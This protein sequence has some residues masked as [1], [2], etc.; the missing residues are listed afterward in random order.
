MR[1]GKSIRILIDTGSNRNYIQPKF[2]NNPI[3][4]KAP[5]N[6]VSVG[7]STI[8]THH[9]EANLFNIPD[10]KVKFF[11][12]PT[13]KSF[14]AILG[15]DS[16][17][18]LGAEIKI[19][20][21]IMILKNG[22]KIPIKE[23]TF[24]AVNT[25]IPRT[26]HLSD[27]QKAK[28]SELLKSFPDL[29]ADPNQKLT[30]TTN[31]KAT[32]RTSSDT[33]VYSKFYQYPMTLK[34][35]VNKQI[36]ELLEDGIIRPS[37]SPYNSPVW[38]VPKKADASGEKKYRMVIDYRKLNKITIADKYPIPEINEV[39]TQ[40]GD[41][42]VFSVLDLKSGFHQISLK[43]NDIE[44]TAFSVNNGKYEF[45]RLP[46][47]LKNAPS[48]FQRALDD[49]LREHIGKI[50]FIY[51]DD[52]IIFSKDDDTHIENLAKIFQT[53]QSAN[54]KCQLDKCE[55]MKNKVEFLG[56]VVSDRGIETNPNKVAAIANYPCPKTLRDLRSFLGLSGYYR[57][58]IQN[59]AKL[60][61]PLTSL[62]RGEDGHVSKRMS[63][64]KL[65]S[66]NN[67]ALDSFKK[68][69]SNLVSKEIILRY[70]D[71]KK[72]FHLTTDASNFAI[73]A[74]LS[75][76]NHPISFLSRTLS[77]AEENYAA[78]EKEMLAIIWAL[79]ALKNYLY[80]KA[81]VKIFTDH[82]PLTHSLS[83]WNGNARIKRWKAYLE[84]YDYEIFYK[85]GKENVV[86]DAL[87]R[88]PLE[89]VNSVASTQHS[90]ESSSHD[91]I[92]SVEAPINVFKNQIFFYKS[93]KHDYKFSIPFPTFHRHEIYRLDYT[94]DDIITDLKKYLNPS[95]INGIHTTENIMGKI[96]TIYRTHFKGIKTRFTQSRVE[97]L[98]D[99]TEQEERILQ[100]H[101][102][103]H[104]N[105]LENQKQL[106]ETHYFPKMKQKIIHLVKQCKVCKEAKYDRHPPNPELQETPTPEYPGHILHIDIYSTERQLVLTAI[107]KF[108]KLAQ[109]RIIN[110]KAIED[111]RTPLRDIIFYFGVPKHIVMDNEKAF[112][113]QSIKFMLEQLQ[114]EVYTAPPYKS[115][116]NGQIERFHSTLSE[117]MRCLKKEGTE[118][119]FKELL[120]RAVYE[121]NYSFHSVTKKRPL[122]VF[123]GR[124][125]TTDPDQY[126]TARQDNI[127]RLKN[128]QKTDRTNHNKN[129]NEIRNYQPGEEI[130]VRINTRLGSKLSPRY[131]K[132]TVKENKHTTVITES[133]K[134]VHKSHI[135]I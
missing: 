118:R 47:G 96:Q 64:K 68:L 115:T 71:F 55:F 67:E 112:N 73:G 116:V 2:V 88:I 100:I 76:D 104:R 86:A 45:T 85:P 110:S 52:I 7:G 50:C 32:I 13:L 97:D 62:L 102:R 125:V 33:P 10:V 94:T 81:K 117:I 63:S 87:S 5:F 129:K 36:K 66:L 127:E 56:F 6:A 61:K 98:T 30:Y 120:E 26:S 80:G 72:E 134:T 53:L 92:V 103:A 17:K 16:L 131:R 42:K 22:I 15:N 65:I 24:E 59:Y 130:F 111:I 41:N 83:S 11:L 91:L 12:L 82:Q 38:I 14:D 51:I 101:R 49:I 48:I 74:V 133:G 34:D 1:N 107:D 46:F 31:V 79:K 114:I 89:Q 93:D 77:K 70:P 25:I 108:S 18:E 119:N 109:A 28:L 123:F 135:K 60:A 128:K 78:N 124:R 29:F 40:L 8:V 126:E 3:K 20:K 35:E 105:A 44:K 121:Y 106:S 90:A 19:S 132:E 69:K 4:N 122:E 21:N 99:E 39:L 43:N 54:M 113:S 27:T 95:V 57:R 84:E 58:F 9:K 23:K 37:R 75:Q